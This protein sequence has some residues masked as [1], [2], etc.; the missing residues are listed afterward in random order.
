MYRKIPAALAVAIAIFVTSPVLAQESLVEYTY[1]ACE[2]NIEEFCSQ[3]TLGEGRLLHCLAAHED[4]ISDEC[5]YALYAAAAVIQELT[6]AIVEEL[7]E[8]VEYLV[9]ECGT[10]IGEH[11]ADVPFG[12][13]RILMCL[14]EN[15]EDLTEECTTAITTLFDS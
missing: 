5:E 15:A 13:G 12:D 3:V 10:D 7:N 1:L 6:I 2:T 4:K 11:C 14:D 8:A 9:V